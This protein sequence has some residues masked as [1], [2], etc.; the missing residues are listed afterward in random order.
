MQSS[1]DAERESEAALKRAIELDPNDP[2]SYANLAIL[3][4]DQDRVKE[5]KVLI[6]K[7]MAVDPS[8]DIGLVARGRYYLQ[9]GEMDKA[10]QDLLA[11]STANPAYAQALLMLAGAYYESGDREPAE[12]AL[13][14][15]DRLDPN[16]PVTLVLRHRD[17]HRRLRSR[18]PR[19]TARRKRFAVRAPAAATTPHSAPTGTPAR[20]STT[21]F[22][23]RASMHGAGSTATPC[24][25]PSPAR[26][27]STRRFP[28]APIRS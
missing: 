7:A 24:S 13:E 3:Y 10:M 11:G 26:P 4:L 6:D 18:K 2:V 27:L 15:A 12:Q 9:T 17:R 25:I 23:C 20:C 21:R 28:A 8:F 22:G 19:S 16:D 1:R 5:A 14:N